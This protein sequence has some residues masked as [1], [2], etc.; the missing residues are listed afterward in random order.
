[1]PSDIDAKQR[2]AW[3][4]VRSRRTA[5]GVFGLQV[6]SN[7]IGV[8]VVALYFW[9]LYP[10]K[11]ELGPQNLNLLAFGVWVAM[12]L[13][14]AVPPNVYLLKRGISWVQEMRPPTS[15]ERKILFGLPTA[16]TLSAFVS[17]IGGAVIFG[18]INE[19]V[20]RTSIGIA[21][22]GLVTCTML[23]LQL[24]GYLR[25]LFA[26]SLRNAPVP[27]D[28]RDVFPRLMLAWLLGSAVP[29][30]AIG[31]V[32]VI[33]PGELDAER[34]AWITAIGALAGGIVMA[35]AARS[36][37]RPIERIR[38]GLLQV[39]QG[40]LN[41]ELPVDDL[42]ELG[43]LTEGVNNL[44][45]GLREREQLRETFAR[46]VGQ[47]NLADLELAAGGPTGVGERR[48]VTVLFVD[49]TGYTTFSEKHEPEEVVDML[50]RFFSVVV[51]V[52]NREG[53]WINKFEGDAALCIFGAP[54][55]QP[56]HALRALRA[57]AAIPDEL[58][59][60]GGMLRARVGL[61]TGEVIAGF[62]GTHERHEY[63][64]IGD[65]VNVAARLCDAARD[66]SSGVLADESTVGSVGVADGWKETGRIAMKGRSERV[67]AFTLDHSEH[68]GA[69]RSLLGW[70]PRV[71]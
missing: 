68:T 62:I 49:L 15:T 42:G 55:D 35:L 29:L 16:E 25:P 70:I 45:A 28:R 26:L 12:L 63:T 51:A 9:L 30:L 1:L 14:L 5:W 18:L 24:E 31:L 2:T 52:V 33:S 20:A 67:T 10:S 69:N 61:A 36:V 21:L 48:E 38:D 56:D 27:K 71:R 54:R 47:A 32:S 65:V 57:G 41:V 43:R 3:D 19:D 6:T 60:K 17:W 7:G 59:Q 8:L 44:A 13:V 46:Q 39:E 53:G 58:E 50:N 23:Y 64:V 66:Q 4:E 34:L 22:A 40:D 37:L 11:D